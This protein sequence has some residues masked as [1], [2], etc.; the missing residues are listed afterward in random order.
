MGGSSFPRAVAQAARRVI[1]PAPVRALALLALTAAYLQ[2][3][4]VKLVDFPAAVAEAAHFGLEPAAPVAALTI[5]VE[6]G[7]AALVLSGVWRWLGA[8]GLAVFTLAASF[9][10]NRFWGMPA[11]P[12]RFMAANAFFEHLGLAGAFVLV[13]WYDLISSSREVRA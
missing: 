9:V 13:A 11:G 3:G 5:A 1:A 8:L 6:L 4:F 7:G 10:A 12:E 2:G